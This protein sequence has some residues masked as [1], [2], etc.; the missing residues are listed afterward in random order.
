LTL[1]FPT[2]KFSCE[3]TKVMDALRAVALWGRS[4]IEQFVIQ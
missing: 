1:Q 4:M 2:V 3:L